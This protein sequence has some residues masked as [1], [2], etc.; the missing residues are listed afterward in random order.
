MSADESTT[1]VGTMTTTDVRYDVTR[2][3]DVDADL[4]LLALSDRYGKRFDSA[5]ELVEVDELIA[6]LMKARAS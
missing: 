5:L 6:L 2:F 1:D 3:V 4:V